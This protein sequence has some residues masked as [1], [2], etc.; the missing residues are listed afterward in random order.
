MAVLSPQ[1]EVLQ[2]NDS[3]IRWLNRGTEELGGFPLATLLEKRL[4]GW[5]GL[6]DCQ[7]LDAG[8]FHHFQL[9][10]MDG[11]PGLLLDIEIARAGGQWTAF[12][13][14]VLPP[15]VDLRETPWDEYLRDETALR[16][17]LSRLFR[18][19]TQLERLVEKWPGVIFQQRADLTFEFVSPR[20][21]ELTGLAPSV[22]RSQPQRFLQVV[23]EADLEHFKQHLKRAATGREPV[24]CIYRV[25]NVKTGRISHVREQREACLS[26]GGLVLGY[27]GVWLDVTRQA[28]AEKRLESAS[29]KETLALVTMGLAHDFGNMLAGIHSLSESFLAQA[30][31]GHPFREGATLIKQNAMQAIQLVQRIVNLHRGKTGERSYG[32]LNEMATDAA[33]LAR[34]IVSRRIQVK[35]Q[36]EPRSL[37]LFVDMIEL[38]QVIIN[39]IINAADA[40]PDGGK[41]S[42]QT[43]LHTELPPLGVVRGSLPRL[44]ALCLTLADTGCGIRASQL[45]SIFEPFF[46]TKAM[47]RGSGLGLYN[48]SLF[49]EKHHGAISVESAEGVGTTFRIWLPQATFTENEDEAK[50]ASPPRRTILLFSEAGRL[51]ESTAEFLRLHGY[52]VVPTSAPDSALELLTSADYQFSGVIVLVEHG[53]VLAPPLLDD[54]RRR[55]LP[56]KTIVQFFGCNEDELNTQWFQKADLTLTSDLPEPEILTRIAKVFEGQNRTGL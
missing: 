28:V 34:K 39:M 50:D 27:D 2:A 52:H 38:R 20:I 7:T 48:A 32:D 8:T 30:E 1:G 3:L 12:L 17:I 14:S 26:V 22:W 35:V 21:E 10:P 16:Q 25:R 11:H 55:R 24:S 47:K 5:A 49:V 56:V 23:H 15:P 9:A 29:W 31:T 42:F 40:M 18:S 36:L 19:E 46:T 51:Q 45:A 54:I 4:P 53:P 33:E 44:P 6:P 13:N 43:S 41:L 37:P